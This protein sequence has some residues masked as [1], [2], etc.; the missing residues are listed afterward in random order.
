VQGKRFVS[1]TGNA[2]LKFY[3]TPADT[4]PVDQYWKTFAFVDGEE[5]SYLRRDRGWVEVS[6]FKAGR[7]FFRKAV[8]ACG[9]RQWRHVAYEYP[10]EARR[11]FDGMVARLAQALNLAMNADCDETVGISR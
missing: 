1:P 5:L 3:A 4:E 8:L 6:G 11:A 10:A 7:V 2:W 9:E